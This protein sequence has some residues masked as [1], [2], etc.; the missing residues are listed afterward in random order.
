MRGLNA[1]ELY[2]P[3]M[4]A[5][6]MMLKGAVVG[7]SSLDFIRKHGA[8]KTTKRSHRYKNARTCQQV[9]GYDANALYLSTMLQEMPF[10]P[11]K[12][13]HYENSAEEVDRSVS[14]LRRKRWFG[15]AELEIRVL[16]EL[17]KK[18]EKILPLFYNSFISEE[19]I[20]EHKKEFLERTK[21]TGVQNYKLCRRLAG[22]KTLLYA[23]LMEWYLDHGLEITAV[24]RTIDYRREKIFTWFV[25]R[26]EAQRRRRPRQSPPRRDVQVVG[27]QRLRKAIHKGPTCSGQSKTSC[28]SMTWTRLASCSRQF[29]KEKV[30][31]NRPFRVEPVKLRMLRFYYYCLDY[32]IDRRDFQLI[33]MDTDIMYLGFSCK[34]LEK[35]VWPELLEEFEETKIFSS[36][37][38]N[39][40]IE[41]RAFSRWSSKEPVRSS[42][43]VMENEE[44]SKAKLSSKGVSKRQDKLTWDRYEAALNGVE[45]KATNRGSGW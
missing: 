13:V 14:R 27:E 3:G 39:E 40:A 25:N 24:H 31:T 1:L 42:S 7:G 6:E 17:W 29:R 20:L 35:P 11:G 8:G 26:E 23:S 16:W 28:G 22:K 37:G 5:Y 34:M 32:F 44:K 36:H 41:H 21:R 33:Q 2:A 4:E 9:L 45:D 15:F 12:L 18:F 38:I 19:A 43:A 10:G 30:T